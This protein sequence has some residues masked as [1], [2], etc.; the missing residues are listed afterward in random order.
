MWSAS[1]RP[2]SP[3]TSLPSVACG[4][5]AERH[6]AA[7]IG[8]AVPWA[9]LAAQA[10]EAQRP[11]RCEAA[12]VG[13]EQHGEAGH[14]AGQPVVVA[15]IGRAVEMRAEADRGLVRLAA[16]Q[17]G[18]QVAEGVELRCQPASRSTAAVASAARC[19]AASYGARVM[20]SVPFVSAPMRSSS[21][22]RS[23]WWPARAKARI[24]QP[25]RGWRFL[26]RSV[27]MAPA[28][29]AR[30][31]WPR[32]TGLRSAPRCIGGHCHQQVALDPGKRQAQRAVVGPDGERGTIGGDDG[33]EAQGR[34]GVGAGQGRGAAGAGLDAAVAPRRAPPAGGDAAGLRAGRRGGIPPAP[35][36]RGRIR[37]RRSARWC[38]R[39][40]PG[41]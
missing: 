3:R 10:D 6:A 28:R 29:R 19:S 23:R 20:P 14:H 40:R 31:G 27:V 12:A 18:V 37:Q 7:E 17:H 26:L 5:Q 41:W 16:P 24:R 39:C 2:V 21:A 38:R 9:F 34:V 15:A 13:G 32:T 35:R 33:V 25:F 1:V 30:H 22:P 36:I 4:R 11:L 8:G